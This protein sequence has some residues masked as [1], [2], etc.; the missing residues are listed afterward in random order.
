MTAYILKKQGLKPTVYLGAKTK[1][2]SLGSEWTNG[3]YAIIETDEHDKSFLKTPSYLPLITNVDNDHLFAQGP[4]KTNFSLLKKAF[5]IFAEQSLSGFI[6]LNNDDEFLKTLCK[7]T[8]KQITSFGINKKS[9]LSA[10]NIQY[11][12]NKS[13]ADLY[14]KGKF[15]GKLNLVVPEKENIYNALG[16]IL[17]AKIMNSF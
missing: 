2:Y 13:T 10:K 15:E 1:D 16:A 8:K 6:V 11:L 17:I 5:Q 9:D 4:Y 14:F 12:K 3:E 7:K